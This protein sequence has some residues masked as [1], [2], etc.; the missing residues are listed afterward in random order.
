MKNIKFEQEMS[1][2]PYVLTHKIW[3]R[4]TLKIIILL[5]GTTFTIGPFDEIDRINKRIGA[6]LMEHQEQGQYDV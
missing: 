3:D 4:K 1:L 2:F 5:T 6:M